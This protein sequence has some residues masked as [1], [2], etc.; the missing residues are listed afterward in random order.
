MK[1]LLGFLESKSNL[2][3]GLKFGLPKIPTAKKR[4]SQIPLDLFADSFNS[5]GDN[6]LKDLVASL[7]GLSLVERVVFFEGAF[8]A[9]ICQDMTRPLEYSRAAE[10]ASIAPGHIA[11]LGLG[12]GH[13]LSRLGSPADLSPAVADQYLGWLAMD[14]HGM[15]EGYFNWYNSVYELAVPEGL[16]EVS[17]EAFDQGLGR[18]IWFIASSDWRSIEGLVSRFPISRRFNLW[19]GIGLMAGFWGADDE[20]QFKKLFNASGKFKAFFQQ[21]VAHAVCMRYDMDEVLDYTAAASE[22]ICGAPTEKVAEMASGYMEKAVV[23]GLDSKSYISWQSEIVAFFSDGKIKT[24]KRSDRKLSGK[25]F[26]IE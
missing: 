8:S 5:V 1:E 25:R 20:Q 2:L 17:R 6:D 21:G 11:G 18:A 7:S 9:A 4:A 15:H 19:R 16:C 23:N 3:P 14:A 12:A 10:L 26:L 13:A 24:T 22:L